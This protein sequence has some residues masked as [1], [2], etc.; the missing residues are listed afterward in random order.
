M[1]SVKHHLKR[2]LALANLTYEEIITV[3][4]QIEA[5][6]NSRPLTRLSSNPSD[7]VALTTSHF[8]LGETLT[9]LPPPQAQDATRFSTFSRYMRTQQLE[10]P[11]LG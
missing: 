3:L 10:D 7:L 8:L 5:I 6:L 11:F 4:T 2:I 1:K 9:V